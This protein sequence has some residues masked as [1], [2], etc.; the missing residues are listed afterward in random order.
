M[1]KII[2]VGLLI[3]FGI[4]LANSQVRAERAV[5]AIRGTADGSLV[6]GEVTFEETEDALKI[7]RVNGECF[8]GSR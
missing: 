8:N 4:F 2:R 1:R 5:A 6:S 7:T 3:T